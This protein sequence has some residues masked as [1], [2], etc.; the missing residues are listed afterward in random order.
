MRG[1]LLVCTL[2]VVLGLSYADRGHHVDS[3][4]KLQKLMLNWMNKSLMKEA[5]PHRAALEA[6]VDAPIGQW[7]EGGV[8]VFQVKYWL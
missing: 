2:V 3:K 1:L 6:T 5:V 4:T 7:E 8:P